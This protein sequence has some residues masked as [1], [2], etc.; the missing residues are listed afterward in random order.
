MRGAKDTDSWEPTKES[1]RRPGADIEFSEAPAPP[2][3]ISRITAP[4]LG[5]LSGCV[6]ALAAWRWLGWFQT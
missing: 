6:L 3:L 4:L 2:S 1:F 5:M